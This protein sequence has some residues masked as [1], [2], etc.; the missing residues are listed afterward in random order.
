[1]RQRYY[2]NLVVIEHDN[3]NIKQSSFSTITAA[4]EIDSNVE[5]IILGKDLEKTLNSLKNLMV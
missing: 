1:M 2:E 5:A 3:K 4:N